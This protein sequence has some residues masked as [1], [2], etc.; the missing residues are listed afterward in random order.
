MYISEAVEHKE[1]KSN[2]TDRIES[3]EAKIRLRR[4]SEMG[5]I[6]IFLGICYMPLGSDLRETETEKSP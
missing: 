5:S 6:G 2:G 1:I 4:N 3:T